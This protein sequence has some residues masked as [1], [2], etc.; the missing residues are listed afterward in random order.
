M[1][2]AAIHS[3]RSCPRHRRGSNTSAASRARGGETAPGSTS[4]SSAAISRWATWA[5]RSR[6]CAWQS[7]RTQRVCSC[8]WPCPT[9]CSL[10]LAACFLLVAPPSAS[11]HLTPPC[12]TL[13]H[14]L[15]APLCS[16]LTAQLVLEDDATLL[17]DAI[18][19]LLREV[20]LLAAAKVRARTRAYAHM[21]HAHD[22]LTCDM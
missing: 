1:C 3:W 22:V 18:P 6:T 11:L 2:V 16:T 8:R 20:R 4:T 12:S 17:P 9:P 7:V 15:P 14:P 21:T 13:L 5:P 10:L 19:A